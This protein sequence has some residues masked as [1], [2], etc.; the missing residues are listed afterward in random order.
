MIDFDFFNV[1]FD[2]FPSLRDLRATQKDLTAAQSSRKASFRFQRVCQRRQKN[3]EG[4]ESQPGGLKIQKRGSERLL[5][6][7][8]S[9]PWV[10]VSQPGKSGK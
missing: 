8:K 2:N 1:A 10:P 9:Q 3:A 6:E 5:D 4:S 7:L